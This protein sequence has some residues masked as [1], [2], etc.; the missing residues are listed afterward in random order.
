[1]IDLSKVLIDILMTILRVIIRLILLITTNLKA[2]AM[3]RTHSSASSLISKIKSMWS[4]YINSDGHINDDGSKGLSLPSAV[5]MHITK[6]TRD[7]PF[8]WCIPIMVVVQMNL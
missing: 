6:S 4:A 3:I 2:L 7:R 8:P 5:S 1:M